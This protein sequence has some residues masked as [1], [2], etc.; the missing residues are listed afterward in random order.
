MS[1]DLTGGLSAIRSWR[2]WGVL[3]AYAACGLTLGLAD[4]LFGQ[5]VLRLGLKPGMATALTVNVL[6]PLAAA[7]IAAAHRAARRLFRVCRGGDR[8]G[9]GR[10]RH[11]LAR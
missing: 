11:R 5:Q 10:L 7:A 2:L 6:L 4:P 1:K 8:G 3:A 9:V